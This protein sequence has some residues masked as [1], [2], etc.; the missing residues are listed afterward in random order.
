MRYLRFFTKRFD[1]LDNSYIRNIAITLCLG[2]NFMCFLST[3]HDFLEYKTQRG[4]SY[5]PR[6]YGFIDDIGYKRYL[7]SPLTDHSILTK[8]KSLPW[9]Q[10]LKSRYS[11][12]C[13]DLFLDITPFLNL[14]YFLFK[15][16]LDDP[17]KN[18]CHCQ[19]TY[20]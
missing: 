11:L 5:I 9:I 13:V 6:S 16:S 20:M 7:F 14:L 18:I 17:E 2:C 4:G 10:A 19:H 3:G 12:K 1:V 8:V 15:V